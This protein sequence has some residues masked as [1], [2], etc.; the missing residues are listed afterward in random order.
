MSKHIQTI[1]RQIG[2]ELFE[3]VFFFSIRVFFTDTDD[4]Q[5]SR[6]REGTI[7]YSTLTFSP[8]YEHRDIY[9]QLCMWD[10]YHVF[11]I[12]ALVFTR[13]LLDEIY[14][15]IE[16]TFEWLIDDAIFVCL[17]DDLIL[18]FCCS[19]LTLE[20]GGFE[21]ASTI[22]LVLQ[23]SQLT[24]YASHFFLELALKGLITHT[25]IRR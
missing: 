21:L 12:T 24:K 23:A 16:L 1:R 4:S 22:T 17:L 2:D 3:C 7:F 9:L 19:D 5:D 13:L 14:H 8:T 15:L 20:T 6:G 18:G 10:D 25:E 11:L